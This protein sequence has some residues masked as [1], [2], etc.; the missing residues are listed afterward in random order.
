MMLF[1]DSGTFVLRAPYK[2]GWCLRKGGVSCNCIAQ[3]GYGLQTSTF[4]VT[5]ANSSFVSFDLKVQ[6]CSVNCVLKHLLDFFQ[7]RPICSCRVYRRVS[8]GTTSPLG[9][10]D[11][12][13]LGF[14]K[15]F[16]LCFLRPILSHPFDIY[17]VCKRFSSCAPLAVMGWMFGS[18][19][20]P[21]TC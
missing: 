6:I 4:N 1:V 8:S 3:P 16:F 21:R 18:H 19:K 2:N 20:C 13:F 10:V 11:V 14:A 5:N 12:L 15:E 7:L 17:Y 9:I